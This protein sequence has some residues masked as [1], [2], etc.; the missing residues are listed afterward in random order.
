MGVEQP[1][2]DVGVSVERGQ[3]PVKPAGVLVIQPQSQAPVGRFA[4]GIEQQQAGDIVAPDMAPQI[5]TAPGL[6]QHEHAR[7]KGVQRPSQ[8]LVARK[9]RLC[10]A[11]RRNRP[12]Q[13]ARQV[14]RQGA[15]HAA[16]IV[17]GQNATARQRGNQNAHQ[18]QRANSDTQTHAK[19]A[20]TKL[21]S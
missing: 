5:R 21:K 7:S 1:H 18:R 16:S 15:R 20:H 2:L 11:L 6:G 13:D 12:I 19:V 10:P 14:R 4:R 17:D 8:H 9:P 3:H